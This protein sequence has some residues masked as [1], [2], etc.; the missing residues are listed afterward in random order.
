M[1]LLRQHAEHQYANEL[2]ALGKTDTKTRPPN[3]K[4]SPWAVA[5]YLLGGKLEDG[6][7]ITP[8]YIGDRRVAE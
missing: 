6:T 2:A 4:L 3:W 1:N 8:K 5:T 7:V